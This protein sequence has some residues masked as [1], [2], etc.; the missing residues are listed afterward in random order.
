MAEMLVCGRRRVVSD[1]AD[2]LDGKVSPFRSLID[3]EQTADIV[4]A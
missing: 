1:I 2:I 4:V 3:V